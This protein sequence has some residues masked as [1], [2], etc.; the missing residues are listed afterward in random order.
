MSKYWLRITT[1][2][3]FRKLSSFEI[4]YS[5]WEH[6]AKPRSLY[7]FEVFPKMFV[8]D[9]NNFHWYSG[10]VNIENSLYLRKFSKDDQEH[11]L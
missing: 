7:V 1:S 2:E 3:E 10:L 11:Y 4:T 9:L 6:L 8:S 5:F